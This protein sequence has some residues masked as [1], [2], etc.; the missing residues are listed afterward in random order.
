MSTGTKHDKGKL[1]WSLMDDELLAPLIPV[2]ARGENLYGFQNWRKDFGSNYRR[3]FLAAI[4]RHYREAYKRPLAMNEDDDHVY[5][6]AQVAV[7]ALF[8]LYHEVER[9]KVDL[10]TST[11]VDAINPYVD[12]QYPPTMNVKRPGGTNGL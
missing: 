8:L 4:R 7:N 6:L 10:S 9:T 3:R 11:P 1:D 2:L 12:E 5:H